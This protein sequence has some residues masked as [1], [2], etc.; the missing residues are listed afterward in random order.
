MQ[1]L[2]LLSAVLRLTTSDRRTLMA[3]SGLRGPYPLTAKGV[4]GNVTHGFP[5]AYAL[6]RVVNRSI[7]LISHVG[8]SDED[9]NVQLHDH[10]EG[11]HS[12]FKFECSASTST[13]SRIL[14]VAGYFRQGFDYFRR[15]L[16][17]QATF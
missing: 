12:S 17:R 9:I 3:C 4:N 15:E 6:G 2:P 16:C 14:I 5:G 11:E 8:R 10:V 1:A 7:F 13:R